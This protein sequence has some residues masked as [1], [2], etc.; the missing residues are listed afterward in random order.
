MQLSKLGLVPPARHGD[1][2]PH[3]LSG[4]GLPRWLPH[5]QLNQRVD[6]LLWR[7][8]LLHG[9]LSVWLVGERL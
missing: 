1:A 4:R 3:Q 5:W 7:D 9:M 6:D 2:T 8:L